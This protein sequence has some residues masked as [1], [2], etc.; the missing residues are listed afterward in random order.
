MTGHFTRTQQNNPARRIPCHNL[1]EVC[2]GIDQGFDGKIVWTKIPERLMRQ[3]GN[4]WHWTGLTG[5]KTCEGRSSTRAV[6]PTM[7]KVL[8]GIT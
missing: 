3:I 6:A 2:V 5:E 8:A 7:M 4:C 1:E